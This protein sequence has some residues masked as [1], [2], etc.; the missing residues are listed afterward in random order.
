MQKINYKCLFIALIIT[1]LGSVSTFAQQPT[2]ADKKS[3]VLE[4]RKLTGADKVNLGVNFSIADVQETLLSLVEQ[5]KEITNEQ[6]VE[7]K[8]SAT[9]AGARLDKGIKAFFTDQSKIAPL[10]EGIIYQI[11][12]KSFTENELRELI[13]FYRTSTGQKALVFLPSLSSQVQ[14]AFVDAVVPMLQSFIQPKIQTETEQLKQKLIEAK[15]KK[16]VN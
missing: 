7:L 14:K 13:A 11:Y 15:V 1:V 4:F 9:E 2:S 12:D 10:S 8:K 6:K 5:D 16:S 3:L